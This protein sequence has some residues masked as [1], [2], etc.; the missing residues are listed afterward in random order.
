MI[1]VA[2]IGT[3]GHGIAAPGGH[4]QKKGA[5][6]PGGSDCDRAPDLPPPSMCDSAAAARHGYTAPLRRGCREGRTST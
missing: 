5:W 2:T 3:E 6:A 4:D 1:E